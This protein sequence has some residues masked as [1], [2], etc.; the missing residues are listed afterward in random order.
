MW[1]SAITGKVM[2]HL[3]SATL[4]PPKHHFAQIYYDYIYTHTHVIGMIAYLSKK[5]Y[6]LQL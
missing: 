1:L 5:A 2:F 4:I 3:M 6:V